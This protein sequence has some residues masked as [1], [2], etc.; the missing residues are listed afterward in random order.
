MKRRR[1]PYAPFPLRLRLAGRLLDAF[2]S[3]MRRLPLS[4]SMWLGEFVGGLGYYLLPGKKRIAFRNL[5]LVFGKESEPGRYRK[6]IKAMWRNWGRSAAEFIRF[7]LYTPENIG[8][9]VTWERWE[10]LKKQHDEG[11]GIL[12]MTAHFGNWDMLALASSLRGIPVHLI[13]K[14]LRSRF[15]N[16]FWMA[17]RD[18]G[19]VQVIFKKGAAREII[20]VLRKGGLVASVLDQ[21]TKPKEGG[22]FVDFFGIPASTLDLMAVLAGK[23]NMTVTPVYIIRVSRMKHRILVLDPVPFIDKGD[24]DESVRDM[25]QRLVDS[26]EPMVRKYPEQWIWVHRRW[27]RRPPGMPKIYED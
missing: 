19:G 3:F 25:T 6:I 26:M 16:D 22:I 27:K 15:W 13:T 7:P 4:A 23:R 5:E 11:R 9:T 21:D 1:D 20:K 24:F 10:I 18:Y 12:T 2:L 8:R 14:Q 17:K